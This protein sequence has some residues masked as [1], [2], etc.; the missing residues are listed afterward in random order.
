MEGELGA[1]LL[2][3][4]SSPRPHCLRRPGAAG[5]GQRAPL[6]RGRG[7]APGT[8]EKLRLVVTLTKATSYAQEELFQNAGPQQMWK[9]ALL[10]GRKGT[11]SLVR[12]SRFE[13]RQ[14]LSCQARRAYL[15]LP[16]P[17]Q[18]RGSCPNAHVQIVFMTVLRRSDRAF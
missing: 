13:P 4:R 16:L 1:L 15:P 18:H 8:R 11:R 3:F 10:L 17:I 9:T 7:S 14:S 12:G 5:L 6:N 2:S